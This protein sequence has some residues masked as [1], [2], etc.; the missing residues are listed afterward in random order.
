MEATPTSNASHDASHGPGAGSAPGDDSIIFAY[1]FCSRCGSPMGTREIYGLV[2]PVC[3]S[4]GHVVLLGPHPAAGCIIQQAG[5]LLLIRRR[6][7]P[8][9][10]DWAFP[11][12]Y[13][14]WD[15]TVEAAA[16][17]EVEE[18]TGLIV[19]VG[20]IVSVSSYVDSPSKHGISLLF[21]ASVVGGALQ[22]ADD[23]LDAVFFATDALPENIAFPTHRLALQRWRARHGFAAPE[24]GGAQ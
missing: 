24:P 14:E 12:G 5:K 3:P 16:A 2:R 11:A 20:D 21:E 15:E 7:N 18:E 9:R 8:G 23:A 6:F 19:A 22:P 4:C 17:R 13:V 10:G 1:R